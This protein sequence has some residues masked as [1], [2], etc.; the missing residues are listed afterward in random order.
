MIWWTGLAPW[1]FAFPFPGSRIPT[2][3]VL[4]LH[5]R[6]ALCLHLPNELCV[7]HRPLTLIPKPTPYTLHPTPDTLQGYLAHKKQPPPPQDHHMTLGI[8]LL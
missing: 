5:L 6:C 7:K 3:L 1:E 8:A 2:L 4:R